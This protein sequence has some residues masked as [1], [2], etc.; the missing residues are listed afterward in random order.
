MYELLAE[1][2][3]RYF[4]LLVILLAFISGALRT[5]VPLIAVQ[6]NLSVSG[7]SWAQG[8]FSIAWPLFGIV[9]GTILDRQNKKRLA[10][11][12]LIIFSVF[13]V[14]V[15]VFS[16]TT[17]AN[18]LSVF[19]YSMMAGIIVVSAEAYMMTLPPL[20]M[21]GTKLSIFYSMVL[22]LD[23]GFSYFIGPVIASVALAASSTLFYAIII[24][25]FLVAVFLVGKAI[26]ALPINN[27][28]AITFQ[29]ILAGFRFIFSNPHL[30]ALTIL[31]FFLSVAF[32]AFLTSFVIFV[33]GEHYLGLDPSRYGIMFA[34]YAFGAM[35]G[36]LFIRYVPNAIEVRLAVLLDGLGTAAL[37]IVPAYVRHVEIVWGT[38]FLAGFGLSFWFVCITAF[39]QRLT[40]A[41][42]L[43]RANSAFRV[44]G[45]AGMPVGSFLVGTL[46]TLFS[47]E[48]AAAA[49]SGLLL[50]ALIIA[51]PL[52]W[53]A[54]KLATQPA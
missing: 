50:A 37:L 20:L 25:T 28:T 10:L 15:L 3:L 16:F 5:S 4:C 9:V 46:A 41:E 26:P 24:V 22:F 21:S 13:F 38:T 53:S 29:Y 1:K 40:P 47:L 48:L 32:G 33:T 30:S 42:L 18:L 39:R 23:F 44:I 52:L 54:D 19:G 27:Q 17:N 34:A 35:T 8:L 14:A 7:V 51:L 31:T 45:Y 11:N 12:A 36:A 2:H 43:G 6:A 49:I